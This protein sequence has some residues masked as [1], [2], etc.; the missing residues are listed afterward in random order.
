MASTRKPVGINFDKMLQSLKDDIQGMVDDYEETNLP[1]NDDN[2]KLRRF[3]ERLEFLLK[4][5]LKER[6]LVLGGRKDLWPYLCRCLEE[7]RN[8]QEGITL[9]KANKELKTNTG[10]HRYFLRYCLLQCCLADVLQQCIADEASTLQFYDTGS[11]LLQPH[12]AND[13]VTSL[14]VLSD[15]TFDLALASSSHDLDVSWPAYARVGGASPWSRPPSRT[16]SLSSLCS[17]SSMAGSMVPGG[18]MRDLTS[19]SSPVTSH[20]SPVV[21]PCS[22]VKSPLLFATAEE[23]GVSSGCVSVGNDDLITSLRE[24]LAFLESDNAHLRRRLQE[25][26]GEREDEKEEKGEREEGCLRCQTLLSEKE[27]LADQVVQLEI[28][29]EKLAKDKGGERK[30]KREEEGKREE[31]KGEK[32]EEVNRKEEKGEEENENREGKDEREEERTHVTKMEERVVTR[33]E[34]AAQ[35]QASHRSGEVD[36]CQQ[37]L[38]VLER[39]NAD[40]KEQCRALETEKAQSHLDIR[41]I[42]EAEEKLKQQ[43]SSLSQREKEYA[44]LMEELKSLQEK[45]EERENVLRIANER[46]GQL[47]NSEK[48]SQNKLSTAV[49]MASKLK[50]LHME[51]SA[52]CDQ[53]KK[54][55][56]SGREEMGRMM[57]ELER[58]EAERAEKQEAWRQKAEALTEAESRISALEDD[59]KRLEE[60]LKEKEKEDE[61]RREREEMEREKREEEERERG[62]VEEEERKWREQTENEKS[63]L[64]RENGNLRE[65]NGNM[66]EENG[67]L[68]EENK[69]IR[70]EN[71]NLRE[72]I[73]QLLR[74]KDS[75]WHSNQRLEEVATWQRRTG[76]TEWLRDATASECMLCGTPFTLLRRRHHCRHCGR[77]FCSGCVDN[78]ILTEA[79]S[80]R[81]RVCD[82]CFS[83]QAELASIVASPSHWMKRTEGETDTTTC[84]K[85]HGKKDEKSKGK[86][87]EEKE[88]GRSKEGAGE[89]RREEESDEDFAFIS[90]EEI[91]N[92]R[93]LSSSPGSSS[94][95]EASP[96]YKSEPICTS[97]ALLSLESLR[98]KPLVDSQ[99]WVNAGYRYLIP[100]NLPSGITIQWR[101]TSE[102]K[103]VSFGVLHQPE[104]EEKTPLG[105]RQAKE[106]EERDQHPSSS[107]H[108][109]LVPPPPTS[110]MA[111][112]SSFTTSTNT[113]STSSSLAV[114]SAPSTS[115]L[116][117]S[118]STT[119]S[120]L[121]PH[122]V[123]IPTT[124]VSS[125]QGTAI[126]GR[127]S[128]KQPGVYTFLFDN[129]F[130]RY[131]AKKVTFSLGIEAK[132]EARD[133]EEIP[134]E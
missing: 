82:E 47:E 55:V 80:R 111:S 116:T 38:E 74:E 24:K 58:K 31:E 84:A 37:K 59:R 95:S 132:E 76:N 22:P 121:A 110:L 33:V 87:V 34:E 105:E 17:S 16:W 122:R 48:E 50:S 7:R 53:L 11:L 3:C 54:E 26:E 1:I 106:A 9:V 30:D 42:M 18:D 78:W 29:L 107:I 39:E 61:E 5:G 91:R 123:L 27:M 128:T 14:Y 64:Q 120:T 68:R 15:L 63:E 99:I 19:P 88:E 108:T 93:K 20:D 77:I 92:S 2:E 117:P 118:T 8:I 62:R 102:P 114:S 103:N 79:E 49:M 21:S 12:F 51:V 43:V 52:E 75:L 13:L 112:S 100:V 127:L 66:R 81:V 130:A 65:E 124:P 129:S 126:R 25:G 109:S 115:T 71:G 41:K 131:T 44:S 98:E 101:F 57:K 35:K 10:R 45:Y 72:K 133:E 40:L 69:N 60:A 73:I 113:S 86:E 23:D 134:D 56:I 96:K 125:A 36:L 119:T 32:R 4:F 67:N 104:A 46:V 97:S 6:S 94:S 70:E 85:E 83:V 90:E 28:Q 89:G